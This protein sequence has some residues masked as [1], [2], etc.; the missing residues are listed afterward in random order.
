VLPVP[1]FSCSVS[2]R[3][4]ALRVWLKVKP[5]LKSQG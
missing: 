5:L 1:F 4:R 3:W 2:G